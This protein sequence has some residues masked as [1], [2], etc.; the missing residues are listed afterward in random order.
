M[1]DK[2]IDFDIDIAI[3]HYS[4]L[5]LPRSNSN[6]LKEYTAK[7]GSCLCFWKTTQSFTRSSN[8]WKIACDS[9]SDRY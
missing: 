1:M 3:I 5:F 2:D 7:L 4:L 8:A 6:N 9:S